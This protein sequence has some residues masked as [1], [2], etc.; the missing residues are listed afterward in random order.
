MPTQKLVVEDPYAYCRNPM[1]FG[2]MFFYFGIGIGSLSFIGLVLLFMVLLLA[3]IKLVEEKRLE[4]RFEQDYIEYKQRTPLFFPIPA[5]KK[6][7]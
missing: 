6:S 3:Y 5:R 7:R 2:I 4:E 1:S